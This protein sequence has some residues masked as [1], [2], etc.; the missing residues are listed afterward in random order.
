MSAYPM[1]MFGG[2]PRFQYGGFW[3]NVLD[4]WPEYWAGNWYGSDEMYIGFTDGGYYLFNRSYPQD[5]IA[6]SVSL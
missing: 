5:Q 6:L 4:P 2:H 3:L 1:E